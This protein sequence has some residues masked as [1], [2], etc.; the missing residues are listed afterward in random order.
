MLYQL[1]NSID[2]Q[3]VGK[4]P[5]V[6][7]AQIPTTV[8]DPLFTANIHFHQVD[9][10]LAPKPILVKGAK[11]TD[12]ISSV[13][14]GTNLRLLVSNKLKSIL[15]IYNTS[16]QYFNTSV[17]WRGNEIDDY[18]L[19]NPFRFD[20]DEVDFRQS[21]VEVRRPGKFEGERITTESK[22]GFLELL[23]MSEKNQTF[24][25]ISSTRFKE[26][27]KHFIVLR[28]VIGGVGYY[29]SQNLKDRIEHAGCSG[30]RFVP[31]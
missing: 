1:S 2:V 3:E 15:E 31:A 13:V 17:I 9:R 28:H 30:I 16:I 6:E 12:L 19:T 20:F 4:Y 11:L 7:T 21:V 26:T 8:D 22:S 14:I 18:W 24:P 25:L 5:Q 23:E 10:Y 29:V 27:V